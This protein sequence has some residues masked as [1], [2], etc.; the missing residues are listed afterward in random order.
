MAIDVKRGPEPAFGLPH[1]LFR[2]PALFNSDLTGIGYQPS[3]DGSQFLV[4]LP[5]GNASARSV[6]VFTNWQLAYRK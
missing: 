2:E 6:T 1:E 5:V 3:A 4:L